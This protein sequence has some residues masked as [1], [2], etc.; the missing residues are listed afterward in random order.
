MFELFEVLVVLI[1]RTH[2]G[3]EQLIV[4]KAGGALSDAMSVVHRQ[5]G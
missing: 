1:Q 2:E 4:T 5:L 3:L